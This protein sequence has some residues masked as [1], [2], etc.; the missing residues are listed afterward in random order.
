[1]NGKYKFTLPQ[2]YQGYVIIAYGID[3][4]PPLKRPLY[5][6]KTYVTIPSSGIVVTSSMPDRRINES[7]IFIDSGLGNIEN[8]PGQNQR[9][10]FHY[11][12]KTLICGD[13]LH[14]IEIWVVTKE[15][16]WSDQKDSIYGLERKLHEVCKQ[17]V[18]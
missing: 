4:T 17:L 5:S 8:L 9:F 11:G 18:K 7:A 2:N 13:A 12:S 6:N 3:S 10:G 15:S 1:M 14:K 16:I